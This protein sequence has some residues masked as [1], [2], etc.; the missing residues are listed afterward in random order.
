MEL[1]A[2]KFK[3]VEELAALGVKVAGAGALLIKLKSETEE[4]LKEREA[5][6]DDRVKAVLE[7]AKGLL[8]EAEGYQATFKSYGQGTEEI[9]AKVAEMLTSLS[10][11]REDTDVFIELFDQHV[12]ERTRELKEG[13]ERLRIAQDAVK[14]DEEYIA[15]Q[16]ELI[17]RDHAKIADGRATLE[18][19]IQR[20]KKG[21]I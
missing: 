20:L 2:E 6:A 11:L 4:Y 9:R 21:K 8:K 12:S 5:M 19:A 18:R 14:K 1:D 13:E 3:T 7:A 10:A 15:V 17:T 16:K